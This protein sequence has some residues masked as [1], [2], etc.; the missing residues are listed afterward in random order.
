[1]ATVFDRYKQKVMRQTTAGRPSTVGRPSGGPPIGAPSD[2]EPMEPA[3]AAR[4]AYRLVLAVPSR[5]L[6]L[7]AGV[8]PAQ[9]VV[10]LGY[11]RTAS[12]FLEDVKHLAPE[13]VVVSTQIAGFTPAVVQQVIKLAP[14]ATVVLVDGQRRW[15]PEL[16]ANGTQMCLAAPHAR[17]SIDQLIETLPALIEEARAHWQ[18]PA[19]VL[20]APAPRLD[21]DALRAAVEAAV[22]QGVVATTFS[23]KGGDGKTSLAI[24]AAALLAYLGHLRVLLIDADMN[25]GRAVYQFDTPI[26]DCTIM[27]LASDVYSRRRADP[28]WDL[29]YATLHHRLKCVDADLGLARKGQPGRLHVLFGITDVEMAGEKPL[30]GVEGK[31]F[32]QLLLRAA[33]RHF[34]AVIV[35]SGSNP[36]FGPHLGAL[37]ESDRIL[38]VS[39]PD[40]SSLQTNRDQLRK[41][42]AVHQLD[43][44]RFELVLNR[45]SPRDQLSIADIRAVMD[46]MALGAV[47]PEDGSRGL[48]AA[49]NRGRPFV[50]NHLGANPKNIEAVMDGLINV[51][52]L[53]QPGLQ[54]AAIERHRRLYG[55]GLLGV[56]RRW[57]WLLVAGAALT[58]AGVAA[59]QQ[60]WLNGWLR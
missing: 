56:A 39:T 25:T 37:L 35:D 24:S 8:G 23:L 13:A 11:P 4:S 26:D 53:V 22:H 42:L 43:R 1:M 40:R 5:D 30:A 36:G 60:G 2:T 58:A 54:Q 18:K 3:P 12:E 31:I 20:A 21:D 10:V 38:F 34:D 17:E 28:A 48:L 50:A 44:A 27:N 16:L 15:E 52:C 32:M 47:V 51:A 19:D 49:I 55:G 33:R 57:S 9:G 45:F 29:D 41:F 59:V 46:G 14:V 6:Q 7:F